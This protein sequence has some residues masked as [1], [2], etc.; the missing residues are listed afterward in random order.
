MIGSSPCHPTIAAATIRL[1][2]CFSPCYPAPLLPLLPLPLPIPL[3]QHPAF[4]PDIQGPP[5]LAPLS[6]SISIA[7]VLFHEQIA[8][9][10]FNDFQGMIGTGEGQR[11]EGCTV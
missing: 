8:V 3:S 4:N 7:V 1:W 9:V 11:R 2:L 10:N 5:F 6:I